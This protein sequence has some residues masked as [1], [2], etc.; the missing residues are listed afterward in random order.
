[1]GYYNR[2]TQLLFTL[3]TILTQYNKY[4]HNLEVIIV[5]DG[6][7]EEHCLKNIITNYPF[8]IKLIVI[9]KSDKIWINPVISYNI[10]IKNSSGDIIIFQ[11]PEVCHLGDIIQ[12]TLD[13]INDDNYL[14]Y[15][16]MSLPSFNKNEDLYNDYKKMEILQ[17]IQKYSKLPYTWYIHPV[18][19][20]RRYHFLSAMT[21]NT[22]EKIGGFDPDFYDG[23]CYDDDD[24]RNRIEKVVKSTTI[25]PENVMGIHLFHETAMKFSNN[26]FNHRTNLNIQRLNNNIKNSVIFC[27]INKM[28]PKY[29]YFVNY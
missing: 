26:E 23:Y 22:L 10:G 18:Y 14:V 13:H 11:N 17:I 8:H 29:Q 7:K 12:Y 1:M 15:S 16:I 5:D 27:D 2:K 6:S 9:D 21:R 28:I 4:N 3:D 24:F 19:H 20:N 25:E